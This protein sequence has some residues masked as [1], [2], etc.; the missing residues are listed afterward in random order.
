MN[1]ANV[2]TGS[3]MYNLAV[4]PNINPCIWVEVRRH[5]YATCKNLAGEIAKAKPRMFKL[6]PTFIRNQ[7]YCYLK[8]YKAG[9]EPFSL[10]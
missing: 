1:K 2:N 7:P 9:P 8:A 4:V 10:P 3:Y 5:N 6:C